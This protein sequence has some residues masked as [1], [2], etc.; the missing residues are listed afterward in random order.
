MIIK[1]YADLP[2][3]YAPDVGEVVM[4]RRTPADRFVRA[5]VLAV[6]RNRAGN[7][8]IRMQWI[9]SDPNAGAPEKRK[10]RVRK[11][12]EAGTVGWV[13]QVQGGPPL[14]VQINERP[15]P[16]ASSGP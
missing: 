3:T 6:R 2:R 7:L 4:A 11:P 12:I 8:R 10:D 5:V 9:E 1:P 13:T 15:Q 16:S 14:I